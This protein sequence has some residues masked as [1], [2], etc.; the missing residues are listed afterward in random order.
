MHPSL[1]LGVEGWKD[2]R[3]GCVFVCVGEDKR[4]RVLLQLIRIK[5]IANRVDGRKEW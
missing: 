2:G 1:L 5:N 3:M 4:R